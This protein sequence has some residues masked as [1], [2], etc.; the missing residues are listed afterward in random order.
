MTMLHAWL[1]RFLNE[2]PMSVLMRNAELNRLMAG[3]NNCPCGKTRRARSPCFFDFSAL[4]SA[5]DT[6]FADQLIREDKV[7]T[8]PQSPF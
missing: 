4:S 5:V 8:T 6:D 1:W 2:I 7:A 3:E